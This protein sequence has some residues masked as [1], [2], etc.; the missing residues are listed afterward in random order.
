MEEDYCANLSDY[1]DLVVA[2]S[3]PPWN[4]SCEYNFPF[5]FGEEE[6]GGGFGDRTLFLA[7]V[8][9]GLTLVCIILV[10]GIGNF[11]FIVTLARFKKLR[12][13][14]NLLIA[15]L[16]VSDLIVAIVCC[17]FEMDYYVIREL[18][19]TFGQV[20]CSL[21]NY[22]RTTSLYVSTNSLLVIAVDRYLVIVYPLKPRMK[23]QTAFGVLIGVW[24]ISLLIAIPSAYFATETAFGNDPGE[25]NQKIFCGQ[26]WPGD[27]EVLYKSYFLFLLMAEFA[28]PVLAMSLCYIWICREL[29]FKNLPGIQTEQIKN[30][31][32]ARRKTVLLLVGILTAYILCWAPYYGYTIVRDFFPIVL[33]REKHSISVY[34]IVECIAISNSMINTLFFITVKNNTGKF[35]KKFLV[36]RWKST[37]APEKTHTEQ[38]CRSSLP[39]ASE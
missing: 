25:A 20:M 2:D 31:L 34:Y 22:L 19:W 32:R 15:N 9:I 29:W 28:V 38:E 21:I 8:F 23:L 36:H 33:H 10:C 12:N 11:L 26:I 6:E 4:K 13:I 27:H 17:P 39:P 16:A 24:V 1:R 30:R 18:S 35:V 3:S 37:Y 5:L 7:R 14:T